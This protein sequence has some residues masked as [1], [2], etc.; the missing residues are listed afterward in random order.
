MNEALAEKRELDLRKMMVESDVKT[1]PEALIISPEAAFRIAETIVKNKGYYNRSLQAALTA[2]DIIN[3]AL[4]EKRLA[5][6]EREV[7]WLGKFTSKLQECPADEEELVK[8]VALK[9]QGVFKPEEY[10][11]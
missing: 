9:Y 4:K 11:L 10:G 1:S 2:S 7:K 6:S 3:E 8:M 5:L